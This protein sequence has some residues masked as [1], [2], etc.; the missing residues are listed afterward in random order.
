MKL[1]KVVAGVIVQDGKI[2]CT[3]R[4]SGE[5][6]GYFEFPGGKVEKNESNIDALIR[7]IKEELDLEIK[8][9]KY[10]ETVTY[11]YP[12]FQLNMDCY[13]CEIVSGEIKLSCHSEYLWMD[14]NNLEEL[15]WLPANLGLLGRII[16][17]PF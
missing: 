8:V 16:H 5:F 4:L 10:I 17:S 6:K 7:E 3:R 1:I 14:K 13:F 9:N 15:N 12:T 2:L 11:D